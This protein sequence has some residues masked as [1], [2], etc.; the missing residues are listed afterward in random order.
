[1]VLLAG[2]GNG[3]FD[4]V[5]VQRL[6]SE[7]DQSIKNEGLNFAYREAWDLFHYSFDSNAED[8]AGKMHK[9]F[10]EN[11]K[12][13]SPV[14]M[15]SSVE[16]LRALGKP[17]LADDIIKVYIDCHHNS[18]VIMDRKSNMFGDHITDP[19]VIA[20]LDEKFKDF[21]D[22]PD[23]AT[24]LLGMSGGWNPD[25]IT[26]LSSKSVEDFYAM[27]KKATGETLKIVTNAMQFRK[28]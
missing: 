2:I 21:A 19:S 6:A 18:K 24:V 7:A 5:A 13:I 9:S 25:D 4:S 20:A 16:L 17:E 15:N 8:I 14:D 26:L 10:I 11:V 22:K 27:F 12:H 1:M 28:E 3:Y 23:P